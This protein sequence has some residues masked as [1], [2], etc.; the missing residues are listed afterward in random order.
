MAFAPTDMISWR[1]SHLDFSL[2]GW[3]K[4]NR[5]RSGFKL[6]VVQTQAILFL[7]SMSERVGSD[8]ERLWNWISRSTQNRLKMG[9]FLNSK[10]LYVTYS[11]T[12]PTLSDIDF[13]NKMALVGTTLNN[14]CLLEPYIIL[15]EISTYI[16]L[17]MKEFFQSSVSCS[18]QTFFGCVHSTV[19]CDTDTVCDMSQSPIDK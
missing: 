7:K 10:S 11:M 8:I 16:Q 15:N 17:F 13:K 19:A 3:V 4:I 5:T 14:V 18:T 12:D 6:R 9:S 1:G 2:E